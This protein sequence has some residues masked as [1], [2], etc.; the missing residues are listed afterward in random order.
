[1]IIKDK[2]QLGFIIQA[3]RM[4]NRGTFKRTLLD[5]LRELILPD[6]IMAFLYYMRKCSYYRHGGHFIKD[7]VYI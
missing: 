2:K 3:D 4:M 1:M 6:Y 7:Y 5:W